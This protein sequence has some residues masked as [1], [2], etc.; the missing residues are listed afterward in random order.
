[1]VQ[2]ILAS[3]S[4]RRRELLALLGLPFEVRA[5]EVGE[6][7][8]P[9]ETPAALVARL[10]HAKAE[11]VWGMACQG[12]QPGTRPIVI[13]CDTVVVL[14]GEVLGKPRD[15][16]EAATVLRR[17]RGHVHA[18]YSAVVFLDSAAT[19]R[20]TTEIASTAVRMRCYSEAEVAA[21]VASGDPLD[22]AGAYAIQHVEFRPVAEWMGCYANV[23]GLPL[24]HLVGCLRAWSVV[25]TN[26]VPTAC[27]AYTGR[28]C[29][30]Y[31][32]IL[33]D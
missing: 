18:V 5:A 21:Y 28:L 9:G 6:D 25:P 12:A 17:L 29:A 26:H 2:L 20:P 16:A 22:K 14:D 1:M 27:Q 7:P 31:R 10:A 11:A 32:D 23:M 3:G 15:R 24:C 8:C 4:P 30:V 13:G 33:A 19:H